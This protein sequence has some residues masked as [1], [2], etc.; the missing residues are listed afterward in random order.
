MVPL[1]A[2]PS[3]ISRRL[4]VQLRVA[5]VRSLLGKAQSSQTGFLLTGRQFYKVRFHSVA[6]A[7]DA[8]LDELKA[9]ILD[10]V[11]AEGFSELQPIID[12]QLTHFATVSRRIAPE[13]CQTIRHAGFAPDGLPAQGWPSGR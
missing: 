10:P 3:R 6:S 9:E 5:E 4:S 1:F 13:P 12:E 2:E 11:L 7:L 8:E